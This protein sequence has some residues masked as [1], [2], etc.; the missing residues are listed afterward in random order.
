MACEDGKEEKREK[1]RDI[2]GYRGE[3][4]GQ[5]SEI[6]RNWRVAHRKCSESMKWRGKEG[7]RERDRET[8][9]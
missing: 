7:E 4:P 1:E 8:E 6:W 2:L 5:A 3:R 9:R